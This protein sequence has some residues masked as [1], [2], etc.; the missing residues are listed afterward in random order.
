MK[1]KCAL[2]LAMQLFSV[3]VFA[4][5][6]TPSAPPAPTSQSVAPS[7][8]QSVFVV[9]PEDLP[10]QTTGVVID[11]P[12]MPEPEKKKESAPITAA[13]VWSGPVPLS[14]G[15]FFLVASMP[16]LASLYFAYQL[17]LF[18]VARRRRLSIRHSKE[19]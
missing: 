6:T 8:S 18:I 4:A 2:V 3:T 10:K 13:Q 19:N 14:G 11:T 16:V 5:D 12:K 17:Y 15:L 9:A 1:L 7:V